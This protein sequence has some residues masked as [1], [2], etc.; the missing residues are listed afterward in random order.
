MTIE[1]EIKLFALG[2]PHV[3]PVPRPIEYYE[4]EIEELKQM[5]EVQSIIIDYQFKAMMELIKENERLKQDG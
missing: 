3:N 2:I 1:E 5:N 4:N